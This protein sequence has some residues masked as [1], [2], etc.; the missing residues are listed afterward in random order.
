MK[1]LLCVIFIFMT[2]FAFSQNWS[3]F[4]RNYRYNYS[5]EHE[6]YTTIVIFA[7]SVIAQGNDTIYSLNRIAAKCDSCFFY[8]PEPGIEDSNYVMGNQPQFMQRR[9]VYTNN[10][11]RLS[12]PGNYILPQFSS[13]GN[14]WMYNASG[15]ITAQHAGSILKNCFGVT[16]SVR[17]ILL[18][19]NDTILISKQFG[20]V[21]YPARFGQHIYYTL[22][23][24]E[25]AASYEVLSLYGEKVPNY[26]DF[27]KLKPGVEHYYSSRIGFWAG[28]MNTHCDKH[29][30]GRRTVISSSQTN[31]VITNSFLDEFK[32]CYSN[33][34]FICSYNPAFFPSAYSSTTYTFN[35]NAP[36]V[37]DFFNH[38]VYN[39]YN[40][41]LYIPEAGVPYF[42]ILKFG[43]TPNN[44]F[45]KTYG[46][47][48]FS[49]N[50]QSSPM[51]N[52]QYSALYYQSTQ[53]PDVY[54]SIN[55]DPNSNIMRFGET[56]I[57]GYGQTNVFFPGFESEHFYC[58]SAIIDGADTLGDITVTSII[59][60]LKNEERDYSSF[61]PNPAKDMVTINF[62][63]EANSNTGTIE[64]R[65]VFGKLILEKQ[66][67]QA[68][69]PKK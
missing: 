35:N 13:V 9:I 45:F 40:N 41:R 47:S 39:S 42:Y 22:R 46:L 8:Y 63:Y 29:V 3:V 67:L 43:M 26:Y 54:Y 30:F 65:D 53:N 36:D 64:V 21:K 28:S 31:T 4:N 1:A 52:Y 11:F 49:R 51:E 18:S 69:F 68:L 61:G 5:L 66:F 33:C 60:S 16:D 24:I 7:D 15:N 37:T 17:V 55:N 58:T 20:I 38:T 32:G 62:P 56:F 44:H 34:G 19:T 23:G 50:I 25:N 59:T 6:S 14:S 2:G 27:F 48:C 10:Q 12:D 57:E